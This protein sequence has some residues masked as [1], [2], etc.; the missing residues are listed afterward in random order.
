MARGDD[1]IPI[2]SYRSVFQIERRIYRIDRLVLNPGG[3]PVRGIVY[4]VL[5]LV[6]VL[7]A[8]QLPLVGWPLQL[9]PWWLRLLGLPI[10]AAFLLGALRLEG[11]VF[12]QA[13]LAYLAFL[14]RRAQA[15]PRYPRRHPIGSLPFLASGSERPVLR[16]AYRGRGIAVVRGV[17]G[18]RQRR[19]CLKV[20]CCG[21]GEERAVLVPSGC[22]LE[23][24]AGRRGDG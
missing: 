18:I 24:S 10:A 19:S 22:R 4:A 15:A 9:A 21:E 14:A 23:V 2:R 13:A 8:S 11:R 6:A 5:A 12:H 1:R 16:L 7:V 17:V 20:R 3:V